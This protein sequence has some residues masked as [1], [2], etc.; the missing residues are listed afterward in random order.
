MRKILE[1][2][3]ATDD[4]ACDLVR[5]DDDSLCYH[6][7]YRDKHGHAKDVVIAV[8]DLIY[9]AWVHM[10]ERE[11]KSTLRRLSSYHV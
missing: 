7:K 1:V 2:K 4:R 3:N 5:E 6:M 10:T 8:S 11:R 9:P